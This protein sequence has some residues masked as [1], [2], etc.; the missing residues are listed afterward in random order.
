M[1]DD[2]N[3]MEILDQLDA[4]QIDASEAAH[5]LSEE[6]EQHKQKAEV[7]NLPKRWRNWWV[8]PFSIGFAMGVTGWGLSQ[9]G[10]WWWVCAGPLMVLGAIAMILS[11]A[12]YRSPWV[13]IRVK[14]GEDK[15]PRRIAISL[16]IPL[17]LTARILR[18]RGLFNGGLDE[19]ALDDLILALEGNLST[20]EPIYIEV[21][22]GG[23]GEHIEVYLG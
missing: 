13:H 12:T 18:W 11:V 10:G 3:S 4:G 9:L 17:S 14:T 21:D 19:T 1:N 2:Q 8:I 16:P 5:R 15:W 7:P 22:E 20:D 6:G 23:S